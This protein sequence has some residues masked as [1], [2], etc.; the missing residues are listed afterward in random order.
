MSRKSKPVLDARIAVTKDTRQRLKDFAYG[1]GGEYNQVIDFLLFQVMP[2][3][4]DPIKVGR[5]LRPDFERF[6]DEEA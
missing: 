4:A 2:T 6:I 1:L 3:G 5:Q